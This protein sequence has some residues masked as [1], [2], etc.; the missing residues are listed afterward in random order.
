[1]G[2]TKVIYHA[3]LQHVRVST[4]KLTW[5]PLQETAHVWFEAPAIHRRHSVTMFQKFKGITFEELGQQYMSIFQ[6]I[7]WLLVPVIQGKS[8]FEM[9]PFQLKGLT[10]SVA[11]LVRAL[12]LLKKSVAPEKSAAHK[13]HGYN[14]HS[15]SECSNVNCRM[16]DCATDQDAAYR[17]SAALV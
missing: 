14:K 4:C 12:I 1:M 3:H 8:S 16:D 7:M 15:Q 13:K 17:S 10:P 11:A 5:F 6:Q 2:S 9:L